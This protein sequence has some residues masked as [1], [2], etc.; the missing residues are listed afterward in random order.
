[1]DPGTCKEGSLVCGKPKSTGKT[2]ILLIFVCL[3]FAFMILLRTDF[4]FPL[5]LSLSLSLSLILFYISSIIIYFLCL[6]FFS[7]ISSF[8]LLPLEVNPLNNSQNAMDQ[9]VIIDICRSSVILKGNTLKFLYSVMTVTAVLSSM[10][11]S[12]YIIVSLLIMKHSNNSR[13]SFSSVNS[14]RLLVFYL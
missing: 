9:H 11:S 7:F 8:Y 4:S 14:L 10:V 6:S 12:S 13:V 5:P 3:I 2:F 1:M